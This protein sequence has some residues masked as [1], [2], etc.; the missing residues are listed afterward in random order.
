MAYTTINKFTDYFNTKLYTGNGSSLAVDT[1]VDLTANGG[2]CIAKNRNATNK[3]W[4][5][6]DTIRGANKTI[7]SNGTGSEQNYTTGITGFNNNGFQV[8]SATQTNGNGNN[9]VG[10]NF[11]AGTSVTGS[12]NTAGS[13]NSTVSVNT[14]SGFS[15]VKYTGTSAVGTVGHG[16]SSAPKMVIVKNLDN[17]S[18]N[19]TVGTSLAASPI[20]GYL[21]LNTGNSWGADNTGFNSTNPSSTVFSIGTG[22]AY[23]NAS[24]NSFIAYCFADVQ[25]FSKIG[26]Y[27]GNANA[28]GPFCYTG[29]F[30][31]F[32]MVKNVSGSESWHVWDNKRS[33]FNMRELVLYPNGAGVEEDVGADIDMLSNGFK[34]RSASTSVN[35]SS[36]SFIYM[37]F[38]QSIVGTNGVTAKA[39]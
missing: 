18:T 5:W 22:N 26:S 8:G 1:G 9:L 27:T 17:G 34:L 21:T 15:I 24:G 28:N 30:P 6:V 38:G 2:L 14:T 36:N 25:G 10:Y 32:V 31:S 20:T 7:H 35:G 23:T 16:L 12:A 11:K 33:P 13:I 29:F 4:Y 19:W 37:A 39:R 3:D